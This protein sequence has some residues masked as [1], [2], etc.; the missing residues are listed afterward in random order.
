M[1][2]H[3]TLHKSHGYDHPS[4]AIIILDAGENILTGT[5]TSY[6]LDSEELGGKMLK[7]SK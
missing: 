2:I 4:P 1:R 3:P 7:S 6:M 5:I